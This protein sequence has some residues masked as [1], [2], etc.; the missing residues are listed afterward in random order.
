MSASVQSLRPSSAGLL[1][2]L[3]QSSLGKKYVMAATG[4]MLFGFVIVHMIGN[5][6]FF[7]GPTLINEY[8]ESLKSK[9]P[10]LWGARS[11][12]SIPALQLKIQFA[13]PASDHDAR[14]AISQNSNCRSPHIHE[15]IDGEEEKQRL[16]GQMKRS[17]GAKDDQQG[18]A[19][20]ASGPLAADQQR[21]DH[22]DLLTHA[23]V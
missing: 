17:G 4:L 21:Q 9:P 3:W 8:A 10:I 15:L 16:H 5:L 20:H 19:R 2:K 14:N 6:Q 12:L 22:H 23:R 1:L 18:G 11:A 7:G 13:F